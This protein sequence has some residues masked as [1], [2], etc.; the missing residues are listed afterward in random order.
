MFPKIK[1]RFSL[2]NSYF[3]NCHTDAPRNPLEVSQYL[4][5]HGELPYDREPKEYWLY[6]CFCEYQKRAW[7]IRQ[8]FF[9]PPKTAKRIAELL[10]QYGHEQNEVLDA[11]CGFGM[12]SKELVKEWFEVRGF[13]YDYDMKELYEDYTW[14]KFMDYS[15]DG[16]P[17][18][19]IKNIVSNP[20][21][22]LKD[23][24]LFLEKLYNW[25]DFDGIAVLLVP[26]WFFEKERPKKL[27]E[28]LRKFDVIH[29]ENMEEPFERTGMHAQI[30][31]VEKNKFY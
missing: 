18:I 28:C 21:Y 14:A 23:I 8:Q 11:C 5:E 3:K 10:K 22:D 31:I 1:K 20:P 30:Y 7:V 26:H 15:I 16:Y 29:R 9:T 24:E 13:D 4:K 19:S 25:L 27:V 6:E 2:N 17:E 12:L